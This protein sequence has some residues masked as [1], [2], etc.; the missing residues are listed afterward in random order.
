MAGNIQKQIVRFNFLFK[1]YDDMYRSA[2]RK[3]DMPELVLWILYI[4]R[5]KDKCTQKDLVDML[6]HLKQSI[7]SALKTLINGGYVEVECSGENR[8]NKYI[9]L[10]EKGIVLSEDT[11][12]KIVR[13]EN[14]AFAT[15]NDEQRKTILRLFEQ[16]TSAFQK[17]I[18]R[19]E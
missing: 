1:Q 19:I 12:D 7:H 17:E 2:A 6:F 5:E 9:H 10:T 3:F 8:R 14:N 15:L 18:Q 16:F 13:A 11:A 4:L